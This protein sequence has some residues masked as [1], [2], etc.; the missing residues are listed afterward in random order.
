M[1]VYIPWRIPYTISFCAASLQC[2]PDTDMQGQARKFQGHVPGGPPYRCPQ[3]L[4]PL[5]PCFS[6][7]SFNYKRGCLCLS[8]SSTLSLFL[9]LLLLFPTCRLFWTTLKINPSDIGDTVV[10]TVLGPGSQRANV[11][12]MAVF[13]AGEGPKL[14][15]RGVNG[16][17]SKFLSKS[18]RRPISRKSSQALE[19][20]M[21]E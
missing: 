21:R 2:V 10:G 16:S 13:Y 19:S 7:T 11:C 6:C 1:Y 3:G 14:A 15:T 9:L 8:R 17:R 5:W 18:I 12:R 20:R 4:L